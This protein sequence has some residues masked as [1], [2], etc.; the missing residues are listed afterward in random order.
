MRMFMFALALLPGCA[1][2]ELGGWWGYD[3][4][5]V[6]ALDTAYETGWGFSNVF[7][8]DQPDPVEHRSTAWTHRSAAYVL[9]QGDIAPLPFFDAAW[10]GLSSMVCEVSWSTGYIGADTD[11]DPENTESIADFDDAAVLSTT[12]RGWQLL[13]PASGEITWQATDVPPAGARLTDDG[14]AVLLHRPTGCTVVVGETATTAPGTACPTQDGWAIDKADQ[15]TWLHTD[16]GLAEL[17]PASGRATVW[18][19]PG[20]LVS[21]DRGRGLLFLA[22]RG[23]SSVSAYSRDHTQRWTADL[24][25]PI[26]QLRAVPARGVVAALIDRPAGSAIVYLD[27]ATG[28]AHDALS[29]EGTIDRFSLSVDGAHLALSWGTQ[30]DLFDEAA[31]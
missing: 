11:M 27:A 13:H 17:D 8:Q 1:I 29:V 5:D 30:I 20:D 16:A 24:G 2:F 14:V 18:G 31:P 22:T 3:P 23:Q 19:A 10:V 6:A 4:D 12:P 25:A 15:T 21:F 28:A 26:R 7:E 9:P